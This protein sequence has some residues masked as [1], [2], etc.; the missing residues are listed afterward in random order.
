MYHHTFSILIII[1]N[2]EGQGCTAKLPQFWNLTASKKNAKPQ[3][4][5]LTKSRAKQVCET[6]SSICEIDNIKNERILRDFLNF[7][8]RH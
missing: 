5:N 2:F 7:R 3:F 8:G 4:L 1:S 6:S